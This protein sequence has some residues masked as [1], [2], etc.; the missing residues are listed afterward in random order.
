MK[1]IKPIYLDM[2][3]SEFD[4]TGIEF[5]SLVDRPAIQSGWVAMSE[6]EDKPNTVFV[7]LSVMDE[8]KMILIGKVLIPDMPIFRGYDSETGA[9]VFLRFSAENIF[10]MEQKF[11]RSNFNNNI[12]E[13]HTDKMCNAYVFEN[14]TVDD[15]IRDKASLYLSDVQKGEF[16]AMVQITNKE[17]W[18]QYIKSG[19]LTGFS[20]QGK[21]NHSIDQSELQSKLEMLNSNLDKINSY[22]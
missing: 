16:I 20:I 6:G 18:D 5:I 19:K 7:K 15:P 17:Y 14:W 4:S 3:V 22:L 9:P 2:D 11:A 10:K 21:L 8:D 13:M 12:N 1:D